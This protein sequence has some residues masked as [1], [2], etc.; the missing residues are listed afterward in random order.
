MGV[1]WLDNQAKMQAAAMQL[2]NAN[3]YIPPTRRQQLEMRKANL[4]AQLATVNAALD[5]LDAHPDLEKFIDVI[6]QAG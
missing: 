3:E 2:A 4:E 6:Q 1:S 5:A